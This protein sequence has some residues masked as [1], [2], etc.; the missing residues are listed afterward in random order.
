MVVKARY[1][2]VGQTYKNNDDTYTVNSVSPLRNEVAVGSERDD[3]KRITHYFNGGADV[4][5]LG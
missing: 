3:G 1:L 2:Q 5:I 4:E